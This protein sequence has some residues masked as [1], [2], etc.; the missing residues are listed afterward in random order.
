M[1]SITYTFQFCDE[2]L[3]LLILFSK[4]GILLKIIDVNCHERETNV[5]Y[6]SGIDATIRSHR[7]LSAP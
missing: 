4:L 7:M 6:E 3:K 2:F 5:V 1:T